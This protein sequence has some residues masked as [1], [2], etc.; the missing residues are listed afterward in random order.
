MVAVAGA[1]VIVVVATAAIAETAG[2]R[3]SVISDR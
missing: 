2:N 1:A 3:P